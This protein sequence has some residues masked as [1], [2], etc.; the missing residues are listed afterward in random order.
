MNKNRTVSAF[1]LL[2][3]LLVSMEALAG[4]GPGQLFGPAFTATPTVTLTPA[5]TLTPTPTATSTPTPTFTPS[6]VPTATIVPEVG[7]PISND[8]WEITLTDALSRKRIFRGSVYYTANPG[9]V[10]VD[11][12]I[13]V[14]SLQTGT[15]SILSSD[16]VVIDDSEMSW[17]V[18]WLGRQPIKEDQ[19]VDPFSISVDDFPTSYPIDIEGEEYFR[20]IYVVSNTSSSLRYQFG[21]LPPIPFTAEEK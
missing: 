14:K 3:S 10:F 19:V 5:P 6:P 15:N 16:I 12:A 4:C 13:K 7:K 2:T 11:L 1:Y 8:D 9:Y 21:D 20:L 18:L 17:T